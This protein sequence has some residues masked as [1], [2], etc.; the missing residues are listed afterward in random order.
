[1][2][3]TC[4]YRFL[5]AHTVKRKNF[6]TADDH[7]FFNVKNDFMEAGASWR[8]KHDLFAF[9]PEVLK[10]KRNTKGMKFNEISPLCFSFFGTKAKRSIF[11]FISFSSLPKILFYIEWSWSSPRFSACF[12]KIMF[13]RVCP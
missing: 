13:H 5:R 1:M 11:D 8:S 10:S 9:V 4:F 2:Y 7:F 3:Y 12:I 6:Q